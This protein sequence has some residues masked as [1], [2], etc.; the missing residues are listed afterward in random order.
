MERF[1]NNNTLRKYGALAGIIGAVGVAGCNKPNYEGRGNEFTVKAVVDHHGDYSVTIKEQGQKVI[2]QQGEA[3][4]WFGDNEPHQ[5]HNHFKDKSN[6]CETKR[7]VGKVVDA[8]G[9][10]ESLESLRPGDNI[11]IDGMVSD[12][13]VVGYKGICGSQLRPVFTRITDYN[14]SV[15]FLID[16]PII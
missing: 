7:F 4:G 10:E 11:V 16:T 8:Y 2:K 14:E 9:N 3:I 15:P 12:S 13:S 6:G 5:I 1:R